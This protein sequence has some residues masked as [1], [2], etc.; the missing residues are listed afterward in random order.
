MPA[1]I[2]YAISESIQGADVRTICQLT[3]F[4]VDGTRYR[5]LSNE[6]MTFFIAAV[7]F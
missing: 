5:S 2:N 7:H 1:V 3:S 6:V 4:S